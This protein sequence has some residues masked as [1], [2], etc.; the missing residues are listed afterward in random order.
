MYWKGIDWF[1]EGQR[2]R[3]SKMSR[4]QGRMDTA[5]IPIE[6]GETSHQGCHVQTAAPGHWVCPHLD[7]CCSVL[8]LKICYSLVSSCPSGSFLNLESLQLPECRLHTYP[9]LQK[10]GDKFF[11]L[12]LW[13]KES[14]FHCRVCPCLPSTCHGIYLTERFLGAQQAE[15]YYRRDCFVVDF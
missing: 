12:M 10:P 3:L 5:S 7:S 4:S 8:D 11:P 15:F 9:Q 14:V 1:A 2:S 13:K 6:E